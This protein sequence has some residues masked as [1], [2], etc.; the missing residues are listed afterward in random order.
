MKLKR[1][2]LFEI[3]DQSWFPSW[4]RTCMTRLII[5]MH[6]ILKTNKDL[7]QLVARVLKETNTK[8]IIDLCS[9]SGGPMPE[10]V[11]I[12]EKEHGIKN[13]KL[14]LTDLYPDLDTAKTI[15]AQNDKDLSYLTSPLDATQVPASEKGLRT[16]ICS[17]HHMPPPTATA[18]LKNAQ[19]ANQPI[20]IY[21]ISD[22]SAPIWSWIIAL[23]INAIMC[24]FVTLKVRPLTWQQ[25]IFTYAIPII[26]ICFAWDG[27]VS[28]AR[29]YTINDMKEL[30]KTLPESDYQWETGSIAGKPSG[31]LFLIGKPA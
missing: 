2:Q 26:P 12:I 25:M 16:M 20:L 19:D 27:A 7:P 21:E 29:T 15:N 3:E 17:F 18:I 24:L 6:G 28:N 4:I 14:T 8:Q 10:A 11:E 9:G 23:P 5:V 1:I 13:I 31:K 22:N 30:L